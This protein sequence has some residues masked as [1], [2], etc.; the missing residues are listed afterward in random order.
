[1]PILAPWRLHLV[2]AAG[3]ILLAWLALTPSLLPRNAVFQGVLCAVAALLGYGLGAL[4]RWLFASERSAAPAENAPRKPLSRR[5]RSIA[6]ATASIGSIVMLVLSHIWQQ[7]Q[8]EEL[9]MPA[10]PGADPFVALVIGLALFALLLVIARAIRTAA[11]VVTRSIGRV[12]PPRLSVALGVVL[13]SLLTV[14]AVNGLALGRVAATLDQV[15]LA[16]NDEF[17]ADVPAPVAPELSGSPSSLASWES[18]GRQ[19]RVF[20]ANAPSVEQIAEF[21]AGSAQGTVAEDIADITGSGAVS[22]PVRVYVGGG[23]DGHLDLPAQAATAVA[24]L[25]RAGG[26]D[27]AVLNVV[28]GTGRGWVNENQA[29]ALEFMW[30]GDTATVSMQFSY[31]PSWASYLVDSQRA[32]EAGRALFDAVYAHWS[33][34]P[35][36]ARPLLVVSGESLGSFGSEG[37]FGGSQDLANRTDG[38]LYVGPTANNVLWRQ[39][40]D[41]RDAG[42]PSYLP[43]Y[44]DGDTVRFSAD[45]KHWPGASEWSGSRVGYIQHANDPVTWLDF[46]YAITPPEWLSGQR[47]PGVPDAMLWVPVVTAMQIAVDQ[48]ASGV[49]DGQGHEFGQAPAWGWASILP[50]EG[51]SD[52]ETQRLAD[53][54]SELRTHDIDQNSSS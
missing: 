33:A 49:P 42:S 8:R 22:H 9:G 39:F 21:A 43:V 13:V 35:T 4:L 45:G 47:G 17:S 54:L 44:N 32:R 1:M 12:L 30:G 14:W 53:T 18:L 29:R 3:A 41:A 10:A 31:L 27:R 38:A 48:L 50:P 11:R 24:E 46:G 36:D 51:W 37:A 40:S 34:L 16:V 20:I 25:E 6:A 26:F 19:G 23:T 52:A 2:P 5:A 7:G 15:Y 28:T